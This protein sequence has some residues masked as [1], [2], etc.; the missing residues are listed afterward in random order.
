MPKL[1]N[2]NA[3]LA[4][5]TVPLGRRKLC[6]QPNASRLV[7]NFSNSFLKSFLT[8]MEAVKAI[9]NFK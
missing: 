5:L 4:F 9:A 8:F 1:E 3:L 6:I 2:G 7:Q